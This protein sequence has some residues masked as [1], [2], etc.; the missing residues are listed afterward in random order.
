LVPFDGKSRRLDKASDGEKNTRIGIVV[1]IGSVAVVTGAVVVALL[2]NGL[3]DMLQLV[4]AKVRAYLVVG[5][6]ALDVIA[7]VVARHDCRSQCGRQ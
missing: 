1:R 4:V 6:R 3:S 5:A 2:Q 7:V